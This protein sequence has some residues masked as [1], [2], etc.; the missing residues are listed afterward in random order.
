MANINLSLAARNKAT[1]EIVKLID[2][3]S[4]AGK[5]RIYSGVKPVNPDTSPTLSNTLLAGIVLNDPAFLIP[6]VAGAAPAV[7]PITA[8]LALATGVA[9]WFRVLDSA[10]NPIFDGDV[11]LIGTAMIVNTTQ[12]IIG[13]QVSVTSVVYSTPMTCL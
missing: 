9:V 1:E 4:G 13:V 12:F 11:G 5:I 7:T 2:A 8:V 6:A 10:D 3:G